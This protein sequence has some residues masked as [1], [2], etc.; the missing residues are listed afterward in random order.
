MDHWQFAYG[1]NLF[2][3]QMAARTGPIRTS[4]DRP[5]IAFLPGHRLTFNMRGEDGQIYAN[6]VQPGDGVHGVIYRCCQE[7][8]KKLDDYEDG[9]ERKEMVVIA[10]NCIELVAFVYVARPEWVTAEASP[11]AAYLQKILIGA[12]AHC[13]PEEYIRAMEELAELRKTW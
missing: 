3:D 5:R 8:L 7:S 4:E 2:S 1:S 10:D 13:L 9:Y 11:D 6:I 12:R